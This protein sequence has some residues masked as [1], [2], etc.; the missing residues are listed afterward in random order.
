MY[1][2]ISH[3]YQTLLP[4]LLILYVR[5]SKDGKIDL[6]LGPVSAEFIGGQ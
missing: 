2:T 4:L 1:F 5:Q 6:T 3:T